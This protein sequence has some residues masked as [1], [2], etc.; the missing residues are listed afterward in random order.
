M[1]YW[2]IARYTT[3]YTIGYM[4]E[5]IDKNRPH[6]RPVFLNMNRHLNHGMLR[7]DNAIHP[8]ICLLL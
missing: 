5:Y 3:G 7:Q 1:Q 4:D 2:Y 8:H 6:P